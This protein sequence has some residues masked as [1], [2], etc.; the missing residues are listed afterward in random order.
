VI[1]T[2]VPYLSFQNIGAGLPCILHPNLSMA[3][4]WVMASDTVS[5]H[6]Y[7]VSKTKDL[8]LYGDVFIVAMPNSLL[9]EMNQPLGITLPCHLRG[10]K[11][12]REL[13]G[14]GGVGKEDLTVSH[15]KSGI[16]LYLVTTLGLADPVGKLNVVLDALQFTDLLINLSMMSVLRE[17][18]MISRNSRACI[19]LSNG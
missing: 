5:P 1:E 8:G 15:K 14:V 4:A 19:S 11:F 17:E 13:A 6:T 3:S 2:P 12:R 10:C 9:N 16:I 18:T 7:L